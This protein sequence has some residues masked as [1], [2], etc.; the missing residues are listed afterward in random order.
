MWFRIEW[1]QRKGTPLS[2]LIAGMVWF[3]LVLVVII[4]VI[5]TQCGT[6]Q[7]G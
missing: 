3:A 1:R 4:G 2:G 7:G 6:Q 5:A